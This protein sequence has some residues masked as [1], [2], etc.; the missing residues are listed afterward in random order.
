MES[1]LARTEAGDSLSEPEIVRLLSSV[2]MEE[3]EALFATA[4]R[5]RTEHTGNRVF[6]YGFLYLSTYCRN[7]CQFCFYR[8]SNKDSLRYRKS[9]EQIIEA[10]VTLA[11]SGVHLIDLTMGEDPQFFDENRFEDL[12][13]LVAAVTKA[14]DLPVMISPGVVDDGVLAS[15]KESGRGWR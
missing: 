2:Q 5:I 8:K 9:H 7:D 3:T 10:A 14:T 1:I 15:L 6:L 4:R 12:A 13:D 11:E